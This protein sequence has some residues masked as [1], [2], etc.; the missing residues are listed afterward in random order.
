MENNRKMQ[1]PLRAGQRPALPP[2]EGVALRR[3]VVYGQGSGRPLTLDLFFPEDTPAPRP[4]ILF[5]HGGGWSSGSPAQFYRQCGSLAARGIVCA[6]VGYRL[7][8][9]ARYPAAVEDAKCAVRWL[10]AH[11][12]E[13]GVDPEQIGCA[14]ASS[15]GH[16]AAL[17][18]VTPDLPRFEGNG[19]WH[20]YSSRVCLAVLFNPVLDLSSLA[21][22]TSAEWLSDFLGFSIAAEPDQYREASPLT[23][24]GAATAPCLI[25]HGTA[26]QAVPYEQAERFRDV[27]VRAGVPVELVGFPGL[28]HAFFNRSPYYEQSYERMESWLLHRFRW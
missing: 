8:G 9:E 21:A 24:A 16:L 12:S 3:G 20:E 10:R 7:T 28:G 22:D 18:A 19:G 27:L 4:G 2:P 26:D 6:S 14:G 17:L 23:Y 13:L 5:F 25:L 11:A 15:G 1:R